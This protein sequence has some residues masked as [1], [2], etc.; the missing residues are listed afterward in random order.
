MSKNP[1]RFTRSEIRRVYEAAKSTGQP[2]R[3]LEVCADGRIKVHFGNSDDDGTPND[4]GG[5]I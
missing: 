3:S 4:L 2:V 1:Q 5:L